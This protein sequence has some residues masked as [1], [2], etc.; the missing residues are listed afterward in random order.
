MKTE[1]AFLLAYLDSLFPEPGC[2]LIFHN[3]FEC[4]CAV[5]LSAQTTDASVNKVT[6]ALFAAYPDAFALAKADIHDVEKL[7]H[8]I[9]LY[10][11]KA[12]NLI[13]LSKA[14]VERHGG[15]V[16]RDKAKMRELPGVGVKTSN[17]VGAICFGIPAIAVD[18]HVAR[19]SKRLGY[20]K[21]EDE[22]EKIEA[23]LERRF[24]RDSHIRLHYQIIL[25]GREV[26]HAK[27]P[28]CGRCELTALCRYFKKNSSSSG[29]KS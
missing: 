9:G 17:V 21:E 11:A 25:F 10:H 18:T 24:P 5:M 2:A 26:C 27:N 6:P 4:L 19:V 12:K 1:D 15:E 3:P 22:P 20:A 29:K 8:S 7:I 23:K 16:P 28:E 13:G 14:L